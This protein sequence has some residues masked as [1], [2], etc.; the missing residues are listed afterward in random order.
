MYGLD[1]ASVGAAVDEAHKMPVP[2]GFLRTTETYLPA[3]TWSGWRLGPVSDARGI[4]V[5]Y[6]CVE[7]Q[8]FKI[9][10]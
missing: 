9:Y 10:M 6:K 3:F 2:A 4:Y 5:G 8:M 7:I 1:R